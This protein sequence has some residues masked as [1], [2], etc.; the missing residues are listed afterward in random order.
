MSF[1][2]LNAMML[3]GLAGAALPVLVHLLSRRKYDVV[4]WGA[5]QFL[6]L[7]RR[8][9]R[10]FRLEELLL[11]L[12]RIGLICLLAAALARPWAKGSFFTQLTRSAPRDVAVVIDS[13]YSMG[14]EGDAVTPHAAAIQ[15]AH[16]LTEQLRPGDTVTLLDARDRVRVL[17]DAPTTDLGLIREQLDSLPSPSGTSSL[18]V[19]GLKAAQV[20]AS[21]EHLDRDII[22][23]TDDQS[24]AWAPENGSLWRQFD[25]AIRQ[26]T[27][28][29]RIWAVNVAGLRDEAP[30][31]FSVDRLSLSREL[32]VPGFPLKIQATVRQWGGISERREVSFAVNGQRLSEK[33]AIANLPANGEANLT[34]EHRFDRVGSYLVSV[35]VEHDL[36]PGDN[37]SDAAVLVESGIPALLVDGDPQRDPTQRE[38]FFIN[39]AL[40]PRQSDTSWVL[41]TVVDTPSLTAETL[42]GQQVVIVAD[43][44]R[45]SDDQVELLEEFV[46]GG[47]G[48]IVA[49]GERID[50]DA[51]NQSLFAEGRGLLPAK[52]GT[53]KHERDYPLGDV[54]VSD[55]SLDVSWLTRFRTGSGVDLLE[56][57]F[58]QWWHLQPAVGGDESSSDAFVS[59]K[60]DTGDPFLVARPFGEGTVL[61]LAAPLDADWSTL[62][63]KNDF[64]PFVHELVFHLASRTVGR[65]VEVGSPL[66]IGDEAADD[67][68]PFLFHRPDGRDLPPEPLGIGSGNRFG[69]RETEV[70]GVYRYQPTE[71]GQAP[72][73]YFVVHS[74]RSESNLAQLSPPEREKVA[75]NDRLRFVKSLDDIVAGMADDESPTELWRML[76]LAVLALLVAEILLTRRLV[77]GG[78]EA[79]EEE[80]VRVDMSNAARKHESIPSP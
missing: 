49:P 57:R 6:E 77:Q 78:H 39:A 26:S 27:I 5:M 51:Y 8:T 4:H 38:T 47:G 70:P 66:V 13:S 54:N 50:S 3:V 9:R 24:L 44:S 16:E 63:S 71:A 32:T 19:A 21:G 41:T 35:M 10:R 73:E 67:A 25:E 7:G 28:P 65:N 59:A 74:D 62:P 12:L 15:W 17:G 80:P 72:P 14:W 1:G 11:L 69:L 48:L 2:F 68:G 46:S 18:P 36:L 23:L 40:T 61:Q 52:F 75:A 45:F 53:I 34:F 30:A 37:R 60:L 33:T 56:A 31:N 64:V 29:P 22:L 43:V 58:A 79:I 55:E 20:L 76:L 42:E